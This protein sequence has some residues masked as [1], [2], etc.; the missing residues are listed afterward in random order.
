LGANDP[1]VEDRSRAISRIRSQDR[2][3]PFLLFVSTRLGLMAFSYMGL[4]IMPSLYMHDAE[5]HAFLQPYPAFDG[6]CRWDCGW[7]LRI[8]FQGFSEVES[9]KVFPLYPAVSWVVTRVTEWHPIVSLLLV[10][11]A[12]SLASYVVIYKLFDRLEGRA[13]A[14]WGLMLF[15]A[16]PFAYYQAAAYSEPMMILASASA[17]WLASKNRH[18]WAGTLLGLGMMA[19]HVTIFFGT[20]LL[21]RQI[22][23]RGISP[24]RLLWNVNFLGL[25]IPFAFLAAWS[26]YLGKKVGDPFAYWNSRQIGWGPMVN[27]SVREM[28][29]QIGFLDRPELYFYPIIALIP[30]AGTLALFAKRRTIVLG[31][32]ALTVLGAAFLGGGVAFGRYSSACWPAFLPLG[33]VLSRRPLWQG[34]VVGFLM[35]LQGMFFWLFSHQWHVL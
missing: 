27:W 21:A 17:L 16:Y 19:R 13:A 1:Q 32:A 29:Q 24:R 26:F 15:A 14:R 4:R 23:Q 7:F 20:G 33:V 9:A 11:N 8:M 35:L 3:F 18:L 25:V 6:L 34:P 12:A 22:L 5:R 2:W 28:Y 31:A 10:S 30:A